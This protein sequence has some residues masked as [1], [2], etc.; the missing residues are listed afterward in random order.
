V[1]AFAAHKIAGRAKDARNSFDCIWSFFSQPR[2]TQAAAAVRRTQRS[3]PRVARPVERLIYLVRGSANAGK[4]C[5]PGGCVNL[6]V[7]MVIYF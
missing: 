4:V 2:F 7:G 1:I 6:A 3:A 5:L